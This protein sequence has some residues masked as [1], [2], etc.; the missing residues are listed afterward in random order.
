MN[1]DLSFDRWSSRRWDSDELPALSSP[2][3]P[4]SLT[5]GETNGGSSV[6]GAVLDTATGAGVA[7]VGRSDVTDTLG[8][9]DR[10]PVPLTGTAGLVPRSDADCDEPTYERIESTATRPVTADEAQAAASVTEC[11]G[12][13]CRSVDVPF[14]TFAAP[15]AACRR[16]DGGAD[17][18]PARSEAAHWSRHTQTVGVP[19]RRAFRGNS[20]PQ[21]GTGCISSRAFKSWPLRSALGMVSPR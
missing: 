9:L 13:T 17:S 16:G 12:M 7:V 5:A 18:E 3:S 1:V 15:P 14:L 20:G 8:L 4:R 10:S 11:G 2:P 21:D 6:G 19:I